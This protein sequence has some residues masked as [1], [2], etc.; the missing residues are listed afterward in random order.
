MS[1]S[2]HGASHLNASANSGWILWALDFVSL[3]SDFTG[4]MLLRVCSYG[5]CSRGLTSTR[6]VCQIQHV[7]N[8]QA[9]LI[10]LSYMDSH[11]EELNQPRGF[12]ACFSLYKVFPFLS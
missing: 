8:M 12:T 10:F 4:E 5:S 1:S 3:F 6:A 9:A 11:P 7:T 2:E